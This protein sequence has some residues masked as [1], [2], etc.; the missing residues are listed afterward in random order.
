MRFERPCFQ[1][2]QLPHHPIEESGGGIVFEGRSSSD[3]EQDGACEEEHGNPV[4]HSLLGARV[5]RL[6]SQQEPPEHGGR[7]RCRF[8]RRPPRTSSFPRPSSE[9][10][11]EPS[12]FLFHRF[13]PS[14]P[15]F[16]HRAVLV[17][18]VRFHVA[19]FLST[20]SFARVLFH[21]A[22]CDSRLASKRVSNAR[23]QTHTAGLRTRTC[24]HVKTSMD[25]IC[26][27]V[28]MG[29]RTSTDVIRTC[30]S[31]CGWMQELRRTVRLVHDVVARGC[32]CMHEA[33][34]HAL[35]SLPSSKLQR[36]QQQQHVVMDVVLRLQVHPT[37]GGV[38]PTLCRRCVH[39]GRPILLH[40]V[41]IGA[42][43]T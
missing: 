40:G 19:A 2:K 25:G 33:D 21:G 43:P 3:D 26:S 23:V 29:G 12:F 18:F 5:V 24:P 41:G 34:A 14:S 28:D 16:V 42:P 37:R 22:S 17:R 39:V 30:R 27:H 11:P 32:I 15:S 35:C 9:H 36:Q 4:R 10:L 8:L 13:A 38:V 31:L 1:T 20:R 7:L 6:R